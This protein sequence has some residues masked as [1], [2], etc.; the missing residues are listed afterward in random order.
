MKR[1]VG[2]VLTVGLMAGCAVFIQ[3]AAAQGSDAERQA[4]APDAMRLCPDAIPDVTKVTACMNAKVSQLSEACRV[5][6]LGNARHRAR[7][8]RHCQ[9]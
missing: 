7:H 3:S 6:M 2:L 4:C 8:C 5:A 1:V 9:R